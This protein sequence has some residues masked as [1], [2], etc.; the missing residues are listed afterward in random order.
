MLIKTSEDFKH[1]KFLFKSFLYLLQLCEFDQEIVL[2]D[3]ARFLKNL[4][5]NFND[6][7]ENKEKEAI[8]KNIY[9][10]SDENF[11]SFLKNIKEGGLS[12]S[13]NFLLNS[14]V[15]TPLKFNEEEFSHKFRMGSLSN[16][17]SGLF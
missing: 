10:Y 9:Q 15:I 14:P 5:I 17:V 6:F 8:L 4:L 16:L 3:R 11:E 1:K 2:T 12:L 7:K 13:Q